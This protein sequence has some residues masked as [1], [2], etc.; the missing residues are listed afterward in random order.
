MQLL[1]SFGGGQTV[2]VNV[3]CTCRFCSLKR[4][5]GCEHPGRHYMGCGVALLGW[6]G[7]Q[8]E[9]TWL[10]LALEQELLWD[11]G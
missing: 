10:L 8:Q 2:P 6:V 1:S 5:A 4:N 3:F 7:E 11:P 9:E